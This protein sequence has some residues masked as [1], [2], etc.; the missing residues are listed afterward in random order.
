VVHGEDGTFVMIAGADGLAHRRDV[1]LGLVTK[2]LTEIVSGVTAGDRVIV[3]GLK[4]V[5]D[6]APIVIDR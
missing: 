3:A 6:G 2:A 1:R 5:T 4:D